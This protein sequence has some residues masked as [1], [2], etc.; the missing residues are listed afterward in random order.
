MN[1]RQLKKRR[2]KYW[3][4]A[5]EPYCLNNKMQ[6]D[7]YQCPYCGFDINNITYEELKELGGDYIEENYHNT[8]DGN[9]SG[10]SWTEK[11]KCPIC[12]TR[13]E[14]DNSDV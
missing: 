5:D 13:Y 11:I 9:Y 12:K 10:H 7:Y 3:R 2:I 6:F 8:F 14:Y 4:L 1:K